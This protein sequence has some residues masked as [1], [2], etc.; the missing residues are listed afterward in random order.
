ML[1][2]NFRFPSSGTPHEVIEKATGVKGAAYDAEID[3]RVRSIRVFARSRSSVICCLEVLTSTISTDEDV[4]PP[5]P[6]AFG[7]IKNRFTISAL[8]PATDTSGKVMAR[9]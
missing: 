3:R 2:R 1:S 9:I 8:A 4:L 7:L 5:I 6:T